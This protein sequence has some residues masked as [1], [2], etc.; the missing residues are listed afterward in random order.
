MPQLEWEAE[1]CEYVQA[2]ARLIRP[3]A[4]S[5]VSAVPLPPD[6][7]LLGPRFIPPSFIH[8]RRRQ[9]APEIT[10]DPAYLKPLNI[11][12][13]LYYP[14][15]LTRCPNCRIAGT[16]S[17]IAWNGWTSTGPREVHGLMMEETV[18]GVQLRCKTCE[19]KHAKEA[20]DTEGEGKYC[21]VLTNHLYWKQIEHWEVPG[22]LAIL[23]N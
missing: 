7:P 20:S 17:N 11:V 5:G 16:K 14:E 18:I 1:V 3:P 2:L 4:K 13:P 12:H 22:K 19:A 23:D 10:P 8:T 6:I 15:I 21:F 9:H